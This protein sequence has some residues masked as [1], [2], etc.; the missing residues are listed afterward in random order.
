MGGEYTGPLPPSCSRGSPL[1]SFSYE[2]HCLYEKE[3]V[4]PSLPPGSS[5]GVFRAF[6]F[7]GCSPS[8]CSD[9]NHKRTRDPEDRPIFP[10]FPKTL[11]RDL[12]LGVLYVSYPNRYR[13]LGSKSDTS[14]QLESR[15]FLQPILTFGV[16]SKS[17]RVPVL[18]VCS[19]EGL[20]DDL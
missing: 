6:H 8:K 13:S 14:D 12:K 7:L 2:C 17:N 4:G 16:K 19:W 18:S 10:S 5:Q 20:R 3:S 1:S 9:W 11:T 15:E